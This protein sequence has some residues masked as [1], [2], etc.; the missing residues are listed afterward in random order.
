MPMKGNYSKIRQLAAV[1]GVF[2]YLVLTLAGSW[3]WHNPG[4]E[5]CGPVCPE[6]GGHHCCDGHQH[7]PP[8]QVTGIPAIGE[9]EHCLLCSWA[10]T[11]RLG[12]ERFVLGHQPFGPGDGC[13]GEI[14]PFLSPS[15][16]SASQS[17]APPAVA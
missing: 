15:S 1:C 3:H 12:Q 7:Q 10:T 13:P 6:A 4:A 2:F 16:Y 9:E 17:R 11:A 5:C 8:V 14:T